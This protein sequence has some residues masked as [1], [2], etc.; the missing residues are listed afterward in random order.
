LNEP[1]TWLSVF[2][3]EIMTAFLLRVIKRKG[4]LKSKGT[5]HVLRNTER[6]GNRNWTFLC[7]RPKWEYRKAFCAK[8]NRTIEIL[9]K[10]VEKKLTA[11]SRK[12]T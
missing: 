2:G 7:I 3:T 6:K 12:T 11:H 1:P 5:C 4:G 9:G 8:K 10:N